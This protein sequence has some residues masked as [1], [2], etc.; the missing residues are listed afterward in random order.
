MVRFDD[1]INAD[2]TIALFK[3]LEAIH[4][5]AVCLYVICDNASYTWK[6]RV[7]SLFFFP[8]MH[9]TISLSDFGN[10]SKR[11]SSITDMALYGFQT[12]RR[13]RRSVAL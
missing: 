7:S 4:L 3:Q 12:D 8:R 1:T 2:S 10:F 11:M 5:T 6:P 13:G 9:Q